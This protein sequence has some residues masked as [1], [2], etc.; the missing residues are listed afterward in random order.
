MDKYLL[1]GHILQVRRIPPDQVKENL[2]KGANSRFKK[3]P[4]GDIQ[5]RGLKMPAERELWERRILREEQRREKKKKVNQEYGYEYEMPKVKQVKDLPSRQQRL[6]TKEPLALEDKAEE[7]LEEKPKEKEKETTSALRN[8]EVEADKGPESTMK[9]KTE[10]RVT[11][12]KVNAPAS[13]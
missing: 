4:W 7:N 9:R 12:K 13:A 6:E 10:K 3:I 1:D 5:A 2:F 8:D 11:A